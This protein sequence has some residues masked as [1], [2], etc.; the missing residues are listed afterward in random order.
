L[1]NC[2]RKQTKNKRKAT[3]KDIER[4]VN[5]T[6]PIKETVLKPYIWIEPKWSG[7]WTANDSVPEIDFSD[8]S[9]SIDP[10]SATQLGF[11]EPP[12][13]A[14]LA[15][16][17]RIACE[18]SDGNIEFWI[19]KFFESLQSAVRENLHFQEAAYFRHE[20]KDL[21]SRGRELR[22]ERQRDK[23]QIARALCG[24]IWNPPYG[25]SRTSATPLHRRASRCSDAA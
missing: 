1:L 9:V 17:R 24:G 23:V 22:Q 7:D 8:A 5:A 3:A 12:N 14:L 13:L 6:G 11:S 20:R 4:L 25:F 2:R 21:S 16:L 10:T 15:F 19:R 18:N